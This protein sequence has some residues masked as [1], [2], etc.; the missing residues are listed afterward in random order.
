[1]LACFDV[2]QELNDFTRTFTLSQAIKI[3]SHSRRQRGMKIRF[4][5]ESGLFAEYSYRGASLSDSDFQDGENWVSGIEV[6]D[7]G[8]F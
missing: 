7:G 2:N 8:E 6:V 3:V 4:L 1:M 5:R